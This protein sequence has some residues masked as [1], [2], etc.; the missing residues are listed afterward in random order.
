MGSPPPEK[1]FHCL[2]YPDGTP[3]SAEEILEIHNFRFKELPPQV[4]TQSYWNSW[5]VELNFADQYLLPKSESI[6]SILAPKQ[7]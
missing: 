7:P 4:M 5:N 2:L 1:W 3:Y 6:S